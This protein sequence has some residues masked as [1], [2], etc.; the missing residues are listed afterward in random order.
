MNPPGYYDLMVG[1]KYLVKRGHFFT[2]T[3]STLFNLTDGA[4]LSPIPIQTTLMEDQ[5]PVRDCVVVFLGGSEKMPSA[6]ADIHQKYGAMW[7]LFDVHKQSY[8]FQFHEVNA[9]DPKA[10][11]LYEGTYT[12][13]LVDSNGE[14]ISDG[15][16]LYDRNICR[17]NTFSFMVKTAEA[18]YENSPVAT[19]RENCMRDFCLVVSKHV[20]NGAAD[21]SW[22]LF[23]KNG[24]ILSGNKF[25]DSS[26]FYSHNL[27][28]GPGT[29]KFTTWKDASTPYTLSYRQTNLSPNEEMVNFD[30]SE[31]VRVDFVDVPEIPFNWTDIGN[32]SIGGKSFNPG[33]RDWIVEGSGNGIGNNSDSFHYLHAKAVGDLNFTVFLEDFSDSDNDLEMGGIM[34]R[35]TMDAGSRHYSMLNVKHNGLQSFYRRRCKA[36]ET[37]IEDGANVPMPIYGIWL[38]VSKV[39][40]GFNSFYKDVDSDEWIQL[41]TTIHVDFSSSDFHIGIAVT[42]NNETAM[43]MM[44][45]RDFQISLR[46]EVS[47][48]HFTL[49]KESKLLPSD[50][51]ENDAFGKTI[52]LD[53]DTMIIS[54]FQDNDNG[55]NSG[56]AY[57]FSRIGDSWHEEAKLLPHDG[58]PDTK[59]GRA[60]ALDGDVAIITATRDVTGY[61]V[62]TTDVGSAYVFVRNKGE[63]WEEQAK[64][65]PHDG[66]GGDQFGYAVALDGNT[67]VITALYDADN[68][69]ESGSAYVF[70]YNGQSWEEQAKILPLDGAPM[71]R[72]G[73]AAALKGDTIVVTTWNDSTD[74]GKDSGSAYVFARNQGTWEQDAKLLPSD[75]GESGYFGRAVAFNGDTIVITAYG[76][77]DFG[78]RTGLAYVYTKQG[79]TWVVQAKL[80]PSD[81]EEEEEFGK[82][83][84]LK[85]NTI[86]IT[87]RS[88]HVFI[89]IGDSWILQDNLFPND[90]EGTE[91]F[92]NAVALDTDTIVVGA[93]YDDD[94]GLSSGSAY[95]FSTP[96]PELIQSKNTPTSVHPISKS[97]T[98]YCTN[99]DITINV[100]TDVWP[101]WTNWSLSRINGKNSS[102]ERDVFYRGSS[103]YKERLDSYRDIMCLERGTYEFTIHDRAGNGICCCCGNGHYNVT[104]DGVMIVEGGVFGY[105]ESTNF[106]VG[107]FSSASPSLS[108]SPIQSPSSLPSAPITNNTNHSSP[109]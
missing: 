36:C 10:P 95:L 45:A 31:T 41:G 19:L 34:F 76:H 4:L 28:L 9:E 70:I 1:G 101:D 65:L 33:G 30:E 50:G 25:D 11:C 59:F 106:E 89:R 77:N 54:A 64:L 43:S 60:V 52:A 20:V 55:G 80:L 42:S 66:E 102:S 23:G 32:G 74:N 17:N 49:W 51:A 18:E 61:D 79:N 24:V 26:E 87:A 37:Y 100:F 72:F 105:N 16:R 91:E 98:K 103:V 67:L 27:C 78:R 53:G 46:R 47:E 15:L 6:Y 86:A 69:E 29:Y 75:V 108:F 94:D 107:P 21:T 48:Y 8:V 14:C 109:L 12:Y 92:G 99:V 22:E 71:A 90:G 62:D 35:D 7:S 85:G 39:G 73:R 3:R 13:T 88:T 5:H 63:L 83:V 68:G 84:A 96:L 58:L 81:A 38:R 57:A 97:P 93:Y 82:A 44:K 56:S 2:S 40:G 104:V